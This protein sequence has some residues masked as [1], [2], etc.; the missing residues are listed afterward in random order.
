MTAFERFDPYAALGHEEGPR[1]KGANPAKAYGIIC[2]RR[3]PDQLF[4]EIPFEAS[5]LECARARRRFAEHG[6]RPMFDDIRGA[7]L[8]ERRRDLWTDTLEAVYRG[9]LCLEFDCEGALSAMRRR[10]S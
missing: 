1:A 5:S 2:N 8:L 3:L 4:S 9:E 7:A 6:T 10:L